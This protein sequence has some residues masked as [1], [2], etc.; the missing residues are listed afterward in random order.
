MI[1]LTEENREEMIEAWIETKGDF[2]R[3]SHGE[4]PAGTKP[5]NISVWGRKTKNKAEKQAAQK[6]EI[7]VFRRRKPGRRRRNNAYMSQ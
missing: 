2:R 4:R 7:P 3:Y 6:K 5:P 1:E